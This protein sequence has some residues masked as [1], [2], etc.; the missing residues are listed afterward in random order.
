MNTRGH[1]GFTLTEV[2]VGMSL[3]SMVI[4]GTTTTWVFH[5]KGYN[6]ASLHMNAASSANKVMEEMVFG[7]NH[8]TDPT[9]GLREAE[10]DT[11]DFTKWVNGDWRILY[12]DAKG[13]LNK[14]HYIAASN[15][16]ENASRVI[17]TNVTASDA[18]VNGYGVELSLTMEQS[19][20]G[21]TADQTITTY[22][23]FRN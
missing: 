7:R 14:L 18:D 22:V 23:K 16:V 21:K 2:M 1:N 10:A 8:A 6:A 5:Q 3:L 20:G 17:A 12:Y 13:N 11:L 4:A 15:L 9:V 19:E